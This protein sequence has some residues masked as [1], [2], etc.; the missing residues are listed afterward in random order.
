MESKNY[1]TVTEFILL[2]LSSDTSNQVLF[3]IIILVVYATSLA[4]NILLILAVIFD[5]RLHNPM[6]FFLINL[7]LVNLGGPTVT[8]P[9]MLAN[10]FSGKKSISFTG[11]ASQIFFYLLLG[12]SECLLLV[13]MAYDRFVAICDPLHYT[14]VMSKSACA[15]MITV[16]WTANCVMSSIDIF[17]LCTL[18]FCG[19]NVINHFFCEIPS[20]MHL[21]CSDTS[22]N[23]VLRLGGS[24]ILLLVPPIL[25]LLSYVKII[26]SII[27]IQSGRYKVFST[28]FSHLT[29]VVLFYATVTFMYV[30]P[31]SSEADNTDKIMSVFC[32]IITPLL[33]PLIYSLRNKDVLRA[34]RHLGRRK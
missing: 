17:F 11:C 18:I 27:R 23:D 7:S 15:W 14:T 28:C 25:I 21:A 22:I 16:T 20:L 31:R 4:A 29:V 12:G 3:F 2:G 19:P 9:K 32:T 13:F 10:F 24:A 26:I 1:S 34:M 8:I 5:H 30:R 33:N 6:Y